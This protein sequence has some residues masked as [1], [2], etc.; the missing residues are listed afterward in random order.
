MEAIGYMD[1]AR[2]SMMDAMMALPS[3]REEETLQELIGK[4]GA[5]LNVRNKNKIKEAI[6]N[7]QDVLRAAGEAGEEDMGIGIEEK[8][9][10]EEEVESERV[11]IKEEDLEDLVLALALGEE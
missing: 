7:L 6:K 3:E 5:V 4:I 9:V 10:K 8:K 11:L 1:K 2:S